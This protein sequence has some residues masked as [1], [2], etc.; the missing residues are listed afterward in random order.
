[1][2]NLL[3]EMGFAADEVMNVPLPK[4]KM[5]VEIFAFNVGDDGEVEIQM[6]YDVGWAKSQGYTDEAIQDELE[7]VL[8]EAMERYREEDKDA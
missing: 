6:E 7:T 8:V 4:H 3:T 5:L 1:M 2:R